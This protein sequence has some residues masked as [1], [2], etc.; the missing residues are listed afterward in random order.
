MP[1]RKRA[2]HTAPKEELK[3]E[4]R[5]IIR[6]ELEHARESEHA[7]PS[8]TEA[9]AIGLARARRQPE[10]RALPEH[11]A[12]EVTREEARRV[13]ADELPDRGRRSAKKSKETTQILRGVE[14]RETVRRA[15]K[16]KGGGH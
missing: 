12:A 16:R 4:A 10:A 11:E 1:R 6:E 8:V 9:V 15:R 2:A 3:G 14:A 7:V 13:L 5:D